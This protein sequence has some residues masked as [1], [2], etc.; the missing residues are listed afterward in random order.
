[1]TKFGEALQKVQETIKGLMT[2]DGI[3]DE[4]LEKLTELNTQ[5]KELDQ[6]HQGLEESY[7]K[8]R[9]KYI[10]SITQFG[11][12]KK[13]DEDDG[14]GQPRTFEQIAQDVLAKK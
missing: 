12:T 4:K 5:V 1:M 8:V 13:P 2:E 9:D 6:Q 3:S 10:E 11:T 7:A 14:S